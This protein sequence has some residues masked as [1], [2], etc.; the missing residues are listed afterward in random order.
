MNNIKLLAIDIAKNVFQL[1]GV[2]RMGKAVLKKQLKRGELLSFVAH[3]P[4]C[5]IAME[6]CGGANYWG[7]QFQQRGHQVKLISPQFVKPYVKSNKND[8]NDAQAIAKAASDPDMRFVSLKTVEQQDIQCLHRIRQRLMQQRTGLC[9]QIRGLLAEYGIVLKAGVAAL[10][11]QLPLFLDENQG[12]LTAMTLELLRE[13]YEELVS[14]DQRLARQDKRIETLFKHSDV[15]QRLEKIPGVGP[16]TATA[17]LA[18]LGNGS[19][20]KNGRHFS[21][22]LG[23]VPRQ[24]SSG[25]KQL[26]LGISKRGDSYLRQ[27]L[28]HG[29]R[30]VVRRV[31]KKEDKQSVWLKDLKARR[32]GNRTSVA[33]ANKN[34]RILWALVARERKLSTGYLKH[35]IFFLS[36][37]NYLKFQRNCENK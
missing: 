2:D 19:A 14:L 4:A 37:V 5:T 15:C 34:A 17:I 31:D 21:A 16:L 7:R 36:L 26:L 28:I 13:L 18:T 10:R 24:R 20:F 22:F 8:R 6:A 35:E 32:G 1:H 25:G 27:L 23:L 30:S 29:A 11:K 3:L 9:N 12:D 33:L